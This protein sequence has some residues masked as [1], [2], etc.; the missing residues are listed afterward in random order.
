MKKTLVFLILFGIFSFKIVLSQG[1]PMI[2]QYFEIKDPEIKKG[3]IVSLR[4]KEIYRSNVPY[5]ENIVGVIGENPILVF[6]KETTTTLPVVSYGKTLVRVTNQN[7]EIK[8]GDFITSSNRPGVGEKA[9]ESGFVVGRALENFNEDE[10]LIPVFVSIQYLNLAPKRPTFGGVIQEILS[11][12]RVPENVPEVLRYTFAIFLAGMS[13]LFG[14]IFF[15]RTLREGIVG[16]SRNPLAKKSIQTAM[17]LNLIGISILT[18]AGIGL[19]LFVI[20]Y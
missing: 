19:A 5:D 2:A 18:L 20:L 12:L 10:G 13:F 9:T 14:F 4:N 7:G 17:I 8:K 1:V 16:M 15:L 6:G 11:T 3:D